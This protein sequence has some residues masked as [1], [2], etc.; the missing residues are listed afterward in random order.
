VLIREHLRLAGTLCNW[1]TIREA[2]AVQYLNF[3]RQTLDW[4]PLP[5]HLL[6]KDNLDAM[7]PYAAKGTDFQER[8]GV[9]L[10][11]SNQRKSRPAPR[12][13]VPSPELAI[14]SFLRIRWA[15]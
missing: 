2:E 4:P 14:K 11:E 5:F 3:A 7:A 8:L 12:S 10:I 13:G 1:A 6:E 9:G 15:S